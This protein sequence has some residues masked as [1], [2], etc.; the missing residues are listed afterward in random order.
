MRAFRVVVQEFD[1]SR[2]LSNNSLIVSEP[3]PVSV[4]DCQ[5]FG[6]K[7]RH[8]FAEKGLPIGI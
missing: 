7:W 5:A 8:N 2:R 1:N 6:K 4:D 3:L